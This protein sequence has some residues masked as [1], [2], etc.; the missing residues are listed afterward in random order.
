MFRQVCPLVPTHLGRKGHVTNKYSSKT[1]KERKEEGEGS[2]KEGRRGR[3]K[4]EGR[5]REQ[6]RKEEG[7]ARKGRRRRR[8]RREK[9]R[10][11]KSKEV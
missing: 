8:E 9:K 6:T 5:P 7:R 3:E 1:C 4:L 2:L 11:H 10:R